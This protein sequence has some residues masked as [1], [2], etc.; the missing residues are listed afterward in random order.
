MWGKGLQAGKSVAMILETK[1]GVLELNGIFI[2]MRLLT[3]RSRD[4]PIKRHRV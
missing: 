3:L 2:S 1:D 4:K